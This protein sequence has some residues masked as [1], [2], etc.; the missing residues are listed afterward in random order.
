MTALDR[1]G[2]ALNLRNVAAS[3]YR[4]Y[5]FNSMCVFQGVPLGANEDGIHE[6][7]GDTDN[8]IAIDSYIELPTTDFGIRNK[9][10]LR[11]C[12]IGYESSGPIGLTVTTDDGQSHSYISS[13]A[14]AGQRQHR[15]TVPMGR[16]MSGT[17]WSLSFQNYDGCDFSLDTIDIVPVVL[18]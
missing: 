7:F 2:I 17:Y 13:P 1:F 6:L 4:E 5:N 18:R 11:K 14:V 9:K 15:D 12:H 8:G 10:R 16:N 3:Q